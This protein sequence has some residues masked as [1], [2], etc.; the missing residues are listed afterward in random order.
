MSHH[1][2]PTQAPP[3]GHWQQGQ[4]QQGQGQWQQGQGQWQPPP[5]PGP[6]S[7]PKA[8]VW[9]AVAGGVLVLLLGVFGV[10]AFAAPGFLVDDDSD[11]SSSE[12]SDE[13]RSSEENEGGP[14]GQ[15]EVPIPPPNAS[16]PE[17]GEIPPPNA[18]EEPEEPAEPEAPEAAPAG[19]AE[20]FATEYLGL[21]AAGDAA[22]VDERMCGADEEWQYEDAVAEGRQLTLSEP[23]SDATA[24]GGFLADLIGP[25]GTIDGRIIV[26]PDAGGWCVDTLYVF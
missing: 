9:I 12:S 7:G 19:D 23:R 5:P 17:P 20:G 25:E 3:P 14:G 18:P 2:E 22:G 15:P 11:D 21:V 6:P 8:G 10:T 26:L 1:S 13:P 4:W 16:A 24:P